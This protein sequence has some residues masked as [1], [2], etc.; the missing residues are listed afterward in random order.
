MMFG[1]QSFDFLFNKYCTIVKFYCVQ[2]MLNSVAD[3]DPM[4]EHHFA[5]SGSRSETTSSFKKCEYLKKEK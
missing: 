1:S 3:P 2:D 4:N 5:G